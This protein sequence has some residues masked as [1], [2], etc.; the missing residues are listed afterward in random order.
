MQIAKEMREH[1]QRLFF[2]RDGKRRRRGL[3]LKN[4]DSCGDRRQGL[5]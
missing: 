1:E 5:P 3:S 2:V 4:S